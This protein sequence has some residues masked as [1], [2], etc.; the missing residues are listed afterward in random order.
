MLFALHLVGS[1]LHRVLSYAAMKHIPG[2]VTYAA[3][4][5]LASLKNLNC[6]NAR[7]IY[8]QQC[9]I[10]FIKAPKMVYVTPFDKTSKFKV[11]FK[12]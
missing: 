8:N 3:V 9:H 10:S 11:N 4:L 12:Y 5:T 1:I 2:K 6:Q 7:A